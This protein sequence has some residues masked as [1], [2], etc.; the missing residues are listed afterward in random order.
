M[1]HLN[2]RRLWSNG[3]TN[4][5]PGYPH[6]IE[7]KDN[8][9]DE[10]LQR[11]EEREDARF[12]KEKAEKLEETVEIVGYKRGADVL[13]NQFLPPQFLENEKKKQ[14]RL[15]EKAR[16]LTDEQLVSIIASRAA[17]A[18]KAKATPEYKR[19][20]SEIEYRYC[21]KLLN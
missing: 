18:A 2:P 11:R 5:G 16:T 15:M 10:K 1:V 17:A 7:I 4:N 6:Q 14:K 19:E 20:Y 12:W 13:N 21:T 8:G 9:L 3:S